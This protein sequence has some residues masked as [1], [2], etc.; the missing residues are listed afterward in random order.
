MRPDLTAFADSTAGPGS[1]A[2]L[3]FCS[4]FIGF[5]SKRVLC[6]NRGL[7]RNRAKA[8]RISD[9]ISEFNQKP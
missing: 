2:T 7:R 8:V 6:F 4:P 3:H 9:S 1:L 5:A